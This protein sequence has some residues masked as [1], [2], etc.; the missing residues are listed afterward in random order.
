[1]KALSIRQP[2]AGLIVAGY[3][4]VEN[5]GWFTPYRGQLLIH[6]SRTFEGDM[7]T[8][9]FIA[10]RLD[11]PTGVAILQMRMKPFDH[12][13]GCIIGAAEIWN[14]QDID[15]MPKDYPQSG[16]R[17]WDQYGWYLRN[18]LLFPEPI[19][20]RGQLGLFDV[21]DELVADQLKK[22]RT[23]CTT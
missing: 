16:W 22:A 8:M 6:A 17:D 14:M 20:F 19:P 1:M 23:S 12:N 15:M 18:P 10:S 7:E 2:W 5:R 9:R 3:K 13:R 21:P 11:V 4:D